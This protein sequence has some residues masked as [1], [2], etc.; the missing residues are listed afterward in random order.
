M[1]HLIFI[2]PTVLHLGTDGILTAG[3]VSNFI[4]GTACFG[5]M[6]CTVRRELG[7]KEK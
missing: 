4:G 3:P 1:F 2:L 7:K 5:T 6:L